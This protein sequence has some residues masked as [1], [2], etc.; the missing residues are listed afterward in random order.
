[1]STIE[2]DLRPFCYDCPDNDVQ[3]RN[4]TVM[5]EIGSGKAFERHAKAFC[6][7]ADVCYRVREGGDAS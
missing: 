7:H 3:V 6:G 5:A 1:M 4:G 2:I